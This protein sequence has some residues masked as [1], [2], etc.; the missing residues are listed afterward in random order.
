[1]SNINDLVTSLESTITAITPSMR[2]DTFT[3]DGLAPNDIRETPMRDYEAYNRASAGVYLN[4][5]YIASATIPRDNRFG[6]SI[7]ELG[8]IRSEQSEF[9]RTRDLSDYYTRDT[10]ATSSRIGDFSTIVSSIEGRI[11]EPFITVDRWAND[12]IFFDPRRF[13]ASFKL[14]NFKSMMIKSRSDKKEQ[15]YKKL[16]NDFKKLWEE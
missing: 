2:A 13:R 7:N 1:M 14:K 8:T 4:S 9:T 10:A 11:S 12:D 3:I 16:M 5:D 15:D 6:Y